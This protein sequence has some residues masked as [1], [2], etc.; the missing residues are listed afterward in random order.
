[1]RTELSGGGTNQM[2][3]TMDKLYTTTAVERIVPKF[4]K[5][6]D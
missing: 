6:K 2:Q 5:T 1:L 3:G 4:G